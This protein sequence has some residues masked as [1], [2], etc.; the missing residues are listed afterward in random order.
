ML[1]KYVA[2]AKISWANGFVYRLNFV[3]WR[4][5]NVVQI[6]AVYFLWATITQNGPNQ[7]GYSQAELLTYILGS[8]ILR[9]IVFSSRS[10]DAQSEI[11]SG[12]LN[13]YLVKPLNYF[14]YWFFRDFADKALN[15]AFSIIEVTILILILKPPLFIQTNIPTLLVFIAVTFLSMIVYFYF[16]MIVSMTTF[17]YV[18]HNGWAQRFLSFVL[19]ET[20][21]GGLF[22][23]DILPTIIFN[24]LK[25]LPFVYFLFTPL[26]IYLGRLWGTDLL[27]AV[28]IMSG[29]AVVFWLITKLMWNKGLKIYGAYGR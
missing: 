26:Q 25:F 3:M 16:S 18:E 24:I 14:Q 19:L 5:R 15:I 7:F 22:P 20:L 29:W 12:D 2:A 27:I 6:L 13:N 9:A 23:L 28:A 11:S 10:T 1:S 21:A 17:W 8:S 4:V